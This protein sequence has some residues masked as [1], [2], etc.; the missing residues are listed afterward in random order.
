[1]CGLILLSTICCIIL[2]PDLPL[3]G[4]PYNWARGHLFCGSN[5]LILAVDETLL[6]S[7]L[8]VTLRTFF[9]N[10]HHNISCHMYHM[11]M[12][13]I[14]RRLFN[15]NDITWLLYIAVRVFKDL[16]SCNVWLFNSDK[17]RSGWSE[18]NTSIMRSFA[19]SSLAL[20]LCL[21]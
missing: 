12:Q 18:L 15:P 14:R 3:T 6:F 5:V 21:L 16:M 11:Q 8:W 2:S 13:M 9:C 20:T 19:P 4:F 1:M 17:Q 7:S 10:C